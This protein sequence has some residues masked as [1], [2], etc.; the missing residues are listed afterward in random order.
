M[1]SEDHAHALTHFEL[2]SDVEVVDALAPRM[3]KTSTAWSRGRRGYLIV[4]VLWLALGVAVFTASDRETTTSGEA[5]RRVYSYEPW[6]LAGLRVPSSFHRL[7]NCPPAEERQVDCFLG[8]D[9]AVL[10]QAEVS[11]F[12]AATGAK[13][14]PSFLGPCRSPRLRHG[15]GVAFC[16]MLGAIGKEEM[17]FFAEQ[18]VVLSAKTVLASPREIEGVP[19]GVHIEVKSFGTCVKYCNS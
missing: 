8:R 2:L 13:P 15:W 1:V 11:S 16:S 19:A 10:D 17:W 9:S 4:S 12:I 14:R 18:P 6:V 3:P 5:P 7:H